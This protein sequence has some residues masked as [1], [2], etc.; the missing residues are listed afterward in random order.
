MAPEA[1]GSPPAL[2][3]QRQVWR[4]DKALIDP[5]VSVKETFLPGLP[6]KKIRR[7]LANSVGA[8]H[9]AGIAPH[10][11]DAPGSFSQPH[12]SGLWPLQQVRRLHLEMMSCFQLFTPLDVSQVQVLG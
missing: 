10:P 12:K 11:R 2:R 3:K 8:E 4:W 9:R 7:V 6:E 1:V 5:Q